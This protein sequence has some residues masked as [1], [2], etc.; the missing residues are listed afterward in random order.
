MK[1]LSVN[2]VTDTA[3]GF[4]KRLLAAS[5][6]ATFVVLL[7][8]GINSYSVDQ[9]LNRDIINDFKIS[10]L[11]DQM[12]Y[13]GTHSVQTVKLL[14]ASDDPKLEKAH[15]QDAVVLQNVFKEMEKVVATRHM[16]EEL[17]AA[18]VASAH[19]VALEN[20][21][22]DLIRK[23]KA[24]EAQ[25]IIVSKD[26][27]QHRQ[28]YSEKCRSLSEETDQILE[29]ALSDFARN[30]QYSLYLIIVTIFVLPVIWFLSYKSVRLWQEHL[31]ETKEALSHSEERYD[32]VLR[33]MSV[34]VWDW[35]IISN[36]LYWSPRFREMTGVTTTGFKKDFSEFTDR[37]HPE[38][39]EHVLTA[40]D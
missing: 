24:D 32:L 27:A 37:I 13:I 17:E 9:A 18:K 3:K 35:D 12:T 8:M 29:K 26:Y 25:G 23:H 22:I 7:W 15:T 11:I 1:P 19:L 6:L 33:G 10:S 34:G 28:V 31:E 14:T 39:K 16:R 40:L 36:D 5:Y 38:D 2:T 21:A 4:P 20:T 30:L